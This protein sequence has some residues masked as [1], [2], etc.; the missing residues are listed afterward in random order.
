[1]FISYVTCYHNV[2]MRNSI[3]M[4]TQSFTR[5]NK[6]QEGKRNGGKKNSPKNKL[7]KRKND[8]EKGEDWSYERLKC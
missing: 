3:V 2:V 5:V 4:V 6:R 8:G 1:M 7:K